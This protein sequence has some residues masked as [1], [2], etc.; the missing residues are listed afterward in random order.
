MADEPT[1]PVEFDLDSATADQILDRRNTLTGEAAALDTDTV[2]GRRRHNEIAAEV[3]ALDEGLTLIQGDTPVIGEA[4]TPEPADTPVADGA[5]EVTEP[6]ADTDVV[7]AAGVTGT[8]TETPIPAVPARRES[9]WTAATESRGENGFRVA[10]G[11]GLDSPSLSGLVRT[12]LNSLG[13]VLSG[14]RDSR[15]VAQ[16]ALTDNRF[17]LRDTDQ[18]HNDRVIAEAQAAHLGSLPATLSSRIA[19]SCC[20]T[21]QIADVNSCGT[22]TTPFA[23]LF[24]SLTGVNEA[25]TYRFTPAVTALSD[26]GAGGGVL[27]DQVVQW[28]AAQQAAVDPNDPTTW[29]PCATV[30]CADH[31]EVSIDDPLV[32][33]LDTDTLTRFSRPQREAAVVNAAQLV[34][35]QRVEQAH[36]ALFDRWAS[37]HL[38]F[39]TK[40]LGATWNAAVAVANQVAKWER[41]LGMVGQGNWV[42]AADDEFWRFLG[43]DVAARGGNGRRDVVGASD[44]FRQDAMY[45]FQAISGVGVAATHIAGVGDP[46]PVQA[47]TSVTQCIAAAAPAASTATLSTCG[48]FRLRLFDVSG[49]AKITGPNEFLRAGDIPVTTA[50]LRQNRRPVLFFEQ[51]PGLIFNGCLPP[52]ILDVHV[53]AD[54]TLTAPKE[55]LEVNPVPACTVA[56]LAAPKTETKKV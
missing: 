6:V 3:A 50:E 53:S 20:W 43:F 18:G 10:A 25:C 17:E 7:V 22:P 31:C 42:V 46:D 5:V 15:V 37:E 12:S 23:D 41:A 19:A 16:R 9:V 32:L 52:V 55:S 1:T 8:V 39:T 2:A 21:E 13:P 27:A 48:T 34:Y 49:F 56:R 38:E 26:V 33:C 29:K 54:G 28:T 44:S 14:P 11:A 45:E 4:P 40:V 36:M 47:V 24:P 30:L 35:A 51:W